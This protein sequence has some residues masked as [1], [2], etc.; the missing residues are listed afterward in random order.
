MAALDVPPSAAKGTVAVVNERLGRL[1]P[2]GRILRRSPLSSVIE[3]EALEAGIIAKEA[4]WRS[5]LL[6]RGTNE[7]LGRIKLQRLIRRARR[8]RETVEACRL[9]AAR[10]AFAETA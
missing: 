5:L 1:K 8:Q 3:L 6:A 4:L 7:Q 2:N 10:A 9:E